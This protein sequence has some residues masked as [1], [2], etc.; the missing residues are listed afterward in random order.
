LIG[1]SRPKT[2]LLKLCLTC[3]KSFST[4][5][6]NKIFCSRKC[7]KKLY[8]KNRDL[9]RKALKKGLETERFSAKE[10]FE[11]DGWCCQACGTATLR[12]TDRQ[13]LAPNAPELDH[14]LPVSKGGSHTR[15]NVQLLCR[16]CNSLKKNIIPPGTRLNSNAVFR[17]AYRS[18]D[19]H[20]SSC[21][22]IAG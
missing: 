21:W 1:P 7:N 12:T 10:I 15:T 11:R 20:G 19:K 4:T 13:Y 16:R 3:D 9:R 18:F 6:T 2:E 14:I 17:E 22:I 5:I 8:L